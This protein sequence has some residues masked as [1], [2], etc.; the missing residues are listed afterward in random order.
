MKA[1]PW[2]TFSSISE[3]PTI[4]NSCL[5]ML[6]SA[7]MKAPAAASSPTESAPTDWAWRAAR[8]AS[9]FW[10]LWNSLSSWL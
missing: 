8:T 7:L 6:P 5:E 10:R 1:A 3:W 4:S 9:S 2:R